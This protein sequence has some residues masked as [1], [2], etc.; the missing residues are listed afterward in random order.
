MSD[1]IRINAVKREISMREEL[2]RLGVEHNNISYHNRIELKE[3][4]KTLIQLE[5]EHIT[6]RFG[7]T[8]AV[9][10]NG[11]CPKCGRSLLAGIE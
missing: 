11:Y 4:K 10:L 1:E 9:I 8:R 6:E 5:C 3:L 7:I 2:D